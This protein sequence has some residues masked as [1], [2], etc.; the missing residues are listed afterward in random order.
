[1]RD[2]VVCHLL[3]MY[4]GPLRAYIR[5]KVRSHEVEDVMQEV[6]LRFSRARDTDLRMAKAYLFSIAINVI[7]DLYRGAPWRTVTKSD[8]D[9][10]VFNRDA[11]ERC[12]AEESS[13]DGRIDLEAGLRTIED[14]HPTE[15]AILTAFLSDESVDT[16]AGRLGLDPKDVYNGRPKALKLI[17]SNLGLPHGRRKK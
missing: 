6:S 14:S 3:L 4:G 9:D 13:R 17:R 11:A 5:R 12:S 15:H 7:N 1:L 10:A 2:E 16:T 8:H